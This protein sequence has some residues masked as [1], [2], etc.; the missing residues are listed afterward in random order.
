MLAAVG[1]SYREWAWIRDNATARQDC[2]FD[3]VALRQYPQP[4]GVLVEWWGF[5]EWAEASG[6]WRV[7]AWNLPPEIPVLDARVSRT[8]LYIRYPGVKAYL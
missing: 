4:L 7:E 8:E 6:Y 1:L 2:G 5:A 3:Q